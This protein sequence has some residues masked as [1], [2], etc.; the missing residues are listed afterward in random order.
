[1]STI[2]PALHDPAPA[3][4]VVPAPAAIA[5]PAATPASAAPRR[6]RPP[7][8]DGKVT[9]QPAFVLHSY[10]HKET[11]LIVDVFTREYGRIAL[12]AKGA[13][14]PHS[15]LRGVLQTFQPLQA[16][17]TGKSELRILTGAEWVGACCRWK[18]PPCCAAFI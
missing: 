13:K 2:T 7:A 10:P 11:S 5:P 14:R 9:G 18:R 1:M 4:I 6:S 15:Q 17:W 16:G 12:V 3:S 8:R